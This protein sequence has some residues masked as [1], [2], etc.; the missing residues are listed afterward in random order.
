[1]TA[2]ERQNCLI[3]DFLLIEDSFERFQLIVETGASQ[4]EGLPESFRTEDNLVRGCVSRVWL[5]VWPGSGATYEV[6]TDSESP[7]MKSIAALFCRI[8]SGSTCEDILKTEPDFI[9][10]LEID[11]HLT[12]TRL[13]GLCRLRESLVGL[14]RHMAG[15]ARIE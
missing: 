8:Y 7:A 13:R 12:P 11:R 10:R 6:R 5:A 14:V 1:M 9:A 4:S 15:V 2:S 3:E